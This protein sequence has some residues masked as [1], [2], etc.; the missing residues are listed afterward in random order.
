ML[1]EE[2]NKAIKRRRWCEL[3]RYALSMAEGFDTA[4]RDSEDS[5]GIDLVERGFCQGP[6]SELAREHMKL[7]RVA[8][9]NQRDEEIVLGQKM[10]VVTI[11]SEVVD[12]LWP[13]FGE[14]AREI[15][16]TVVDT[17]V[18]MAMDDLNSVMLTQQPSDFPKFP[19]KKGPEP[20]LECPD[21]GAK[22]KHHHVDFNNNVPILRGA[23]IFREHW[24]F[25]CK[26]TWYRHELH[27]QPK[28][29]RKCDEMEPS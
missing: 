8:S 20:L 9:M 27:N 1:T 24:T 22:I 14:K 12:E 29:A 15:V 25:D 17:R 3:F 16:R 2:L 23:P 4:I 28:Q 10:F 26:A 7:M 5:I 6:V 13:M 11:S 21:C 18:K 19:E